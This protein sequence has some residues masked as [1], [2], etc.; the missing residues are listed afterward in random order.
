MGQLDSIAQR[1]LGQ[2]PAR[3]GQFVKGNKTRQE[4]DTTMQ[5]STSRDQ[6]KSLVIEYNFFTPLKYML[7]SNI[8]QYK[9]PDTLF[10]RDKEAT[11]EI[12]PTVLR[13]AILAFKVSDGLTPASKLISDD[14]LAVALQTIQ[15]T[16]QIGMEY[17]I[18]DM[19]AYLI[20]IKG[21]KIA[22]FRK[23]KEQRAYEQAMAS[24]QQAVQFIVEKLS[25][26]AQMP[27]QEN[28]PPQP[29]PEQ[30]GIKQNGTAN[31]QQQ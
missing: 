6:L 20:S 24:W 28:F 9:G 26:S 15:A 13:N 14:V 16:P 27:T 7:K 5:G 3:A 11:V 8:V 31:Q 2:N 4:F 30:F 21:A 1:T 12:D 18:G 17:N 19:F 23:S 10:S 25:K 22:D 29:T